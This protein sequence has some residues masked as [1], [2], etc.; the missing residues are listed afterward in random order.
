MDFIEK[1]EKVLITLALEYVPPL[2]EPKA[3]I[4]QWVH[5]IA[6]GNELFAKNRGITKNKIIWILRKN[7]IYTSKPQFANLVKTVI[8]L[9]PPKKEKFTFILLY[10]LRNHTTIW[11][12]L[13]RFAIL[14]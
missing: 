4:H 14:N 13:W 11:A 9:K 10:S 8:R 12:R 6:S 5:A 2:S 1:I 7:K 3:V